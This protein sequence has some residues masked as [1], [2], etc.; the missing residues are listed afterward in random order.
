VSADLESIREWLST[1]RYDADEHKQAP[2]V[3]G[4]NHAI[5]HVIAT[6]GVAFPQLTGDPRCECGHAEH[7][8]YCPARSEPIA[9]SSIR[10]PDRAH[11]WPGAHE[12]EVEG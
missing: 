8:G 10:T 7:A 2:Y 6:L 3:V 4:W 12:L 11:D 5:A 9:R 1:Q